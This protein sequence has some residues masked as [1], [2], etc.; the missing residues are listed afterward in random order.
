M[1]NPPRRRLIDRTDATPTLIGYGS[2]FT[3][4][5]ECAGDLVVAG[6]AH[7]NVTVASSITIAD[8]GEWHGEISAQV[9][10]VAGLLE[11]NI[12]V[13]DKL[14]IRRTARIRGNVRAKSIAIATGAV[15]DGDIAVTSGAP[16]VRFEE[17]R[18]GA[19]A[20]T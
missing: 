5:F 10:I 7:G 11:G 16:V 1:N 14:E 2:V 17:R 12:A 8:T 15:I 18:E 9:A 13:T 4:T 3:G 20:K 19:A 6:T